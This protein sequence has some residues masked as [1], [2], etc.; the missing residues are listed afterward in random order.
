MRKTD[1]HPDTVLDALL[2]KMPRSNKAANLKALHEICRRQYDTLS[3]SVRDYS[4]PSIGRLCEA[5]GVFKARVLYNAASA[6]YVALINVWAAYSGPAS[7]KA[8]KPP[9][10]PTSHEYLMR[11]EDPAIRQ[12]MQAAISERDSLRAQVNMLKSQTS[13]VIDRRP[14]GATFPQE[15]GSTPILEPKARLTGSER[16][17]LEKSISVDRLARVGCIIGSRGEIKDRDG[18]TLFE[19]GFVDAV[20]K[21]LGEV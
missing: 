1:I 2:A 9:K 5:R 7:V 18:R 6:D 15:V 8:P 10:V 4:L 14:L 16:E 13:V 11:V 19:V 12:L 17:A 21:I 20:R 3:E